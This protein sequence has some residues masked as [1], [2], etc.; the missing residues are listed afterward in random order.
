VVDEPLAFGCAA[1]AA[2]A[3]T[4]IILGGATTTITIPA[5]AATCTASNEG[6]SFNIGAGYS[7]GPWD[8]SITYFTGE[9][10]GLIATPGEDENTFFEIAA[11]YTL[12]PGLRMSLAGLA[13]DFEGEAVGPADDNDGV[14]VVFGIHAGF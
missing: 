9:E 6:E 12:G 8:F 10:E 3:T 2:S 5:S 4:T 11:S 13:I 14:A 7:T 1:A